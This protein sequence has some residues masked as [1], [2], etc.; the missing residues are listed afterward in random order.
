[1]KAK[2]K[3]LIFSFLAFSF[4]SMTE[5]TSP[6]TGEFLAK[7]SLSSTDISLMDRFV[8]TLNLKYPKNTHPDINTIKKNLSTSYSFE[9]YPF[10]IHEIKE[11]A[12]KQIENDRLEKQIEFV[13]EPI[14]TGN[15]TIS[16]LNIPF[17]S[18]DPKPVSKAQVFSEIF[19]IRVKIPH[20]DMNFKGNLAPQMDFSPTY[21]IEINPE[22]RKKILEDPTLLQKEAALNEAILRNKTIP[23]AGITWVFLAFLFF[24]ASR[25]PFFEKK[26]RLKVSEIPPAPREAIADQIDKL[27]KK[28]GRSPSL[29]DFQLLGEVFRESLK[30]KN[31]FPGNSYTTEESLK[32]AFH[33]ETLNK[34][35]QEKI[36]QV[37]ALLDQI[38]FARREPS[39]QEWEHTVQ[40][41][42]EL[43]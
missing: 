30:Q 21:P 27:Q 37:F 31:I 16:F 28:V 5:W 4:I 19:S 43:T 10:I 11:S 9:P 36:Q 2:F 15:H 12:E 39:M 22:N 13:M 38:K 7:A 23:W 40:L 32:Y 1:M 14:L 3:I 25:Q 41:I 18:N 6:E 20:V 17:F 33:T 35:R 29:H 8:L 24:W 34:E 26:F 42:K